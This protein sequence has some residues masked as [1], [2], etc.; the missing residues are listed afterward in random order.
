[1]QT[2]F[3]ASTRLV[4]VEIDSTPDQL[5]CY[6]TRVSARTA[7]VYTLT[8]EYSSKHVLFIGFS[9]DNT[10]QLFSITVSISLESMKCN[11]KSSECTKWSMKTLL[12][13][14]CLTDNQRPIRSS[15]WLPMPAKQYQNAFSVESGSVQIL[16]GIQARRCGI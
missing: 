12:T 15:T 10:A 2:C 14:G 1:M 3:Q 6:G 4:S 13:F 5:K 9:A 7:L 16:K 11:F 8:D